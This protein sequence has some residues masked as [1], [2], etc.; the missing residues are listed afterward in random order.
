MDKAANDWRAMWG[1]LQFEAAYVMARRGRA[2]EAWA[3]WDRADQM[4][5]RLPL[6]Y[7]HA[8]TSFSRAVMGAHA[9]TVNVEVRHAGEAVRAASSFDP[10]AIP[11]VPRRSRHL[12]EVARAHYQRR[13][14]LATLALLDKA[15]RTAPETAA[16]NS[17][18]RAMAM[19]RD[20]PVLR[21]RHRSA[22]HA[23][24]VTA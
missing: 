24:Q 21:S 23:A 17:Y 22:G 14:L 20:E 10:E 12:I 8:Q 5:R 15:Q 3:Y 13:D 18:A 6:G 2:G 16:Y 9:V 7:R 19:E 11:S 1:A 4:A